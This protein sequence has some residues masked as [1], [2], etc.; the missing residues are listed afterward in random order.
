MAIYSLALNT[1][2]TT[3]TAAC[4]DVKSAATNRPAI[5]ELSVNL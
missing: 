4:W 1:T 3:I 5:M 2:V